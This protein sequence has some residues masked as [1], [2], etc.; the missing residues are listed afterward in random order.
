M[1][2]ATRWPLRT[3]LIQ[4]PAS[5]SVC[6][7]ANRIRPSAGPPSRNFGILARPVG[8]V[9]AAGNSSV[10]HA[11]V[12]VRT[13]APAPGYT[14]AICGVHA[15]RCAGVRERTEGSPIRRPS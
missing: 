1:A 2:L 4:Y 15:V 11:V 10:G 5:A 6:S 12:A 3:A 8:D 13:G 14:R 7:P 9:T